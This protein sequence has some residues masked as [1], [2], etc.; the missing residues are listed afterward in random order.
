[1]AILTIGEQAAAIAAAWPALKPTFTAT[2]GAAWEGS[3]QPFDRPY[4]V[5]IACWLGLTLGGCDLDN[6][7]P[8][9][10][11]LE[12]GIADGVKHG[13]PG[14]PHTYHSAGPHP[15][16]CLFDPA[17]EDW[18]PSMRL[19]D[20][21]VPWT[22]QWLGFLEIWKATKRWTGPERH[23]TP[24]AQA[25]APRRSHAGARAAI[26]SAKRLQRVSEAEGTEAS[27]VCLR[28]VVSGRIPSLMLEKLA[29]T[30]EQPARQIAQPEKAE[31]R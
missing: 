30:R 22:S 16:L 29:S 23:P 15:L 20:T 17:A 24:A 31:P 5:Q 21:I 28:A 3:L 13:L 2:W 18:D 26:P 1:M 19:A 6:F 14:L 8:E 27:R 11:V 25:S 10:R 4:K 7:G 9:V 12:P